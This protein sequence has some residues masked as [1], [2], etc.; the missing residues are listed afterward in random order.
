MSNARHIALHEV[1]KD[2][3]GVPNFLW[4]IIDLDND[5]VTL[6]R[7]DAPMVTKVILKRSLKNSYTPERA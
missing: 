5:T 7:V 2:T 1:W 4:K 6:Q 3:G